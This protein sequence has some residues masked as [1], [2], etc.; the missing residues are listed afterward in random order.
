MKIVSRHLK[1]GKMD[2]DPQTVLNLM[3]NAGLTGAIV[4]GLITTLL[5]Y[6]GVIGG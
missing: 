5:Y 2:F 4:G 6:T 1:E 3:V